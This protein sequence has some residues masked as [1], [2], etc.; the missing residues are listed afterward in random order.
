MQFKK[1]HKMNIRRDYVSHEI[2]VFKELD[3]D[4]NY[5]KIHLMS[6]WAKQIH[7][8]RA[9]QQYCAERHDQAH[10]MNLKGGWNICNHN[11]KFLLQVMTFQHRILW[12]EIRKLNPQALP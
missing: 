12:F 10:K 3:P 8:Y 5:P 1:L 2:N 9:F 4:F 7:R 11:L 6:H